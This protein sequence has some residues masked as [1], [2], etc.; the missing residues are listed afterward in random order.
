MS[1]Y[2]NVEK[3][4]LDKLE[5]IGWEIINHGGGAEHPTDPTISRRT[6]FME[7]GVFD[8]FRKWVGKLNT[9]ATPEQ[10]ERAW[11]ILT[12]QTGTLI[13]ANKQV[14]DWLRNGLVLVGERNAQTGE[15]DPKLRLVDFK[16]PKN[17]GFLAINQFRLDTPRMAKGYI[18][19]DI[20]CIV[21]GLPWVVVECKDED[22]AEPLSDAWEQIRRYSNQRKDPDDRYAEDEGKEAFFHAN[23][24]NVITHGKEA[25]FGTISG[26][27]DYYYNWQDIFP[28]EYK[29]PDTADGGVRQEVLIGGMFNHA[30]LLDIMRSFTLFM[31]KDGNEFQVVCRYQQYRA[32]GKMIE[33]LK[34]GETLESRSGVIW[35][36]QG[37]GKSLTMVFLVRKMRE[38][39]DLKDWKI[40]MV[41]DRNELEE[42]LGET[43]AL[44][45]EGVSIVESRDTLDQLA[46]DTANL[47]LVMIHKFG[48]TDKEQQ[49]LWQ[50][51]KIPPKVKPFDE[52]NDRSKILILIDE[53]H[54]S[55][56]GDMG[57]NLRIA[58]PNATRIGFTGTPL[59]TPRHKIKTAEFFYCR[60]DEFIDT[61]KM[62]DAVRDHATVDV[63]YIGKET[64]DEITDRDAFDKEYELAF[65]T[66]TEAE[67]QEIMKR[68]G[69]MVAYLESDDRVEEIAKD[70]MTHY[71]T[72]ILPNG[73][74]A[75]VV[76]A[77]IPAA[78]RYKLK[79]EKLI[80]EFIAAEE[81]KPESERDETLLARLKILKARAVVSMVG[82]NEPAYITAAR[83]EG[84]GQAVIDA[85]KK[86]FNP[87]KPET[88]IGILCV[89][90]KLLTGFDA[91]I[92][93]VMYLDRSLKEH[94]LMQA[95]AR[96]NR[97]KTGK[98]HGILVDYFGVTKNLAEALGIYT[99]A[100]KA[101]A[102]KDMEEFGEYF[103]SIEKELPAL[104]MSYT[105][106]LQFFAKNA[107]KGA[108]EYINQTSESGEEDKVLVE[109]AIEL[110]GDIEKRAELDGLVKAYLDLL[111]LLFSQPDVQRNH[112]IRAKR[113][114]YLIYSI[115]QFYKDPTMDL[116]FAS[117]KVRTLIDKYVRNLS[118]TEKIEP[119]SMLS[120][121]FPLITQKYAGKKSQASA[122]E[123]AIRW[124]IKERL[125]ADPE[126]YERFKDRLDAI[127]KRYDGNWEQMVKEYEQ[128]K[129][130]MDR[131]RE[132]DSRFT[133]I[134]AP[135]YGCLKSK[136]D[137]ELTADVD[138]ALVR[139]TKN[140]CSDI[141]SAIGIANFWSKPSEVQKLQDKIAARI[142]LGLKGKVGSSAD[143]AQEI[144]GIC[145]SGYCDILRRLDD[146]A[147]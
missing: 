54:R 107:V 60:A 97:T 122:M 129:K 138:A 57:K 51:L 38:E 48:E 134:Q 37:S 79:I 2:S 76:G 114:G 137:V 23:L 13:E 90:D 5:K 96:V 113:L 11:T 35:H 9:W 12:T 21:N 45:G 102:R 110:T 116:K 91:P 140:I 95:I 98:G 145:K 128:L 77:S 120:D 69:D 68:Y 8:H 100:D 44:S 32:V 133:S 22:V 29:T 19:P 30:I 94:N 24:F 89:C 124:Q 146:L 75:M 20:V 78:V 105:K 132:S 85:Y 34:T 28:E 143:A 26:E 121:D 118:I 25:R 82:N 31:E 125:D 135:F 62:N 80:P 119:V 17:N 64:A 71:V 70:L 47:N 104:E 59:L 16:Y 111:D 84:Q 61:Y 43:A 40:I 81:A 136:I 117:R 147:R 92:A 74:K 36:T 41:V 49:E 101:A 67:R 1:E 65:S 123:H 46:G 52:I 93:Q 127:I 130:E 109:K 55:Q 144:M 87:E 33:K 42:Q 108:E 7:C 106:I 66:R 88:G 99:D 58:F 10:I 15:E 83:K 73:F 3:P 112:W 126:F 86:S 139:E 39:F 56:G 142:R 14:F 50:R 4:F 115:Q 131:G 53:A 103:K 63:V 18:V 72:E 6:S 27:F 141:K